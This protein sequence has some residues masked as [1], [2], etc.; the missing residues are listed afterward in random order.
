MKKNLLALI[1]V[2]AIALTS[3]AQI[4]IAVIAGVNMANATQKFAGTSFSSSSMTG[5]H[6]GLM[7][8]ISFGSKISLMPGLLYSIKGS[9]ISDLD[10]TTK[11]NYLEI[12]VNI[13]YKLPIPGLFAYAGPYLG[14]A[15]SGTS[16]MAGL[17]DAMK[18]GTDDSSD[19]KPTDL[20][21]N[22]GV[23]Y[24]LPMKLFVRAQY[25]LGFANVQPKGDADNMIKNKV[26]A[27]SVGY[28]FK[29]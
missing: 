17:S 27:I 6:V 3:N 13:A 23:G 18:I 4:P 26:L 19:I 11:V 29:R 28:Y 2:F 9:K 7:T 10:A 22:I 16:E 12:P 21:L 8:E 15:L 1:S 20:G 25:G 24:N 5:F 14:Y